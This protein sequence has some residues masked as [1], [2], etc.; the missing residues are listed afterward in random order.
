VKNGQSGGAR[1]ASGAQKDKGGTPRSFHVPPPC[2]TMD[3][4]CHVSKFCKNKP[5]LLSQVA[6]L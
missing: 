2:W 3:V 5:Y 1:L 4:D 6:I